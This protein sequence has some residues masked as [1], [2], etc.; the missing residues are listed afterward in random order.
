MR[1]ISYSNNNDNDKNEKAFEF[2]YESNI[3]F[4]IGDKIKDNISRIVKSAKK[5]L[6]KLVFQVLYT[7]MIDTEV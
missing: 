4:L 5:Y 7:L 3:V 1:F 6:Y 2:L